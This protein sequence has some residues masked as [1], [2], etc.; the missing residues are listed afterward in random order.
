MFKKILIPLDGSLR[1]EQALNL[2]SKL[3]PAEERTIILLEATG[4]SNIA[5][6]IYGAGVGGY[7]QMIPEY[8][9]QQVDE[10]WFLLA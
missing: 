5:Y 9:K 7:A 8:K 6:P 1:S 10:Y 4:D 2:V 3:F